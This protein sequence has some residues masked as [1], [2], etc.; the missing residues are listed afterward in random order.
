MTLY[1]A[2]SPGEVRVAAVVD[3]V[4]L[5]YA[6]WR[7]GR[8][9]GVGDVHRGRI[10]AV[11]P[12]MAGAFVAIA[13]ADGFLPDSAGAAGHGVGDI[14]SVR[15]VRAAQGGKGPRLA[16]A[17]T[18]PGSGPPILLQPGPNAVERLAALHPG[19]VVVNDPGLAALLRPTLAD[20]VSIG[21]G[22]G[23]TID[24]AIAA[25]TDPAVAL[26]GGLRATIEPTAALVAIDM[27][28]AAATAGR[29]LKPSKQEAANRAALP[30]LVRQIRL[31]N[32]SGA[33]LLDLAGLSLRK[34]ASLAEPIRTALSTDPL[35]PRL[36]GFTNGGL[37][38]I[39]RPRIH[40][41]LHELL[42]GPHATGLAAL[43][44]VLA[45]ADITN[46]PWLRAA[47]DVASALESDPI[48]LTTLANRLGRP[49][50]VR[51]DPALRSCRWAIEETVRA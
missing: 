44:Q 45:M 24:D 13:G 26:P 51:S 36:L 33:I 23:D 20:R 3:G 34:R 14:L 37:A 4:L 49:L 31:R 21:P 47:P 16:A 41:P 39:Q 27:D 6:I 12:G 22:W 8:P 46:P 5:D 48:A 11:V 38:E 28:M 50:L 42:A 43:R 32:L 18:P 30:A 19:A 9:D 10:T 40:P 17:T 35:N 29:E 15:V 1:A 2:S 25:L 7:P